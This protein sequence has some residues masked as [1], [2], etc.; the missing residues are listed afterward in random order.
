MQVY[1]MRCTTEPAVCLIVWVL[2]EAGPVPWFSGAAAVLMAPREDV[3]AATVTVTGP[4]ASPQV[5]W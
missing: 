5:N 2:C 1:T 3:G 4:T